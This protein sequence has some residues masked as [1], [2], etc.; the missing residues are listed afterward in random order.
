MINKGENEK[1]YKVKD[2]AATQL[3]PSFQRQHGP[4]TPDLLK[5]Q[6]ELEIQISM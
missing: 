4:V 5:L 1:Q 2:M 3:H 6:E